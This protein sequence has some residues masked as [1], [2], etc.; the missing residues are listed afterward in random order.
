RKES[1]V[2]DNCKD[3]LCTLSPD[4]KFVS[5]NPASESMWGYS[6]DELAKTSVFALLKEDDQ[7][8][9]R[10][11]LQENSGQEMSIIQECCMQKKDGKIIQTQWSI[12]SKKGQNSLFCTVQDI[13]D[14]KELEE[15]RQ[16]F[17]ALASHDLRTPLMAIRAAMQLAEMGALGDLPES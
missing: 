8:K 14:R 10:R 15:L 4:G 7:E 2:F 1:A 13:T 9:V 16:E 5:T 6:R 17:L 12:S 3:V 11:V